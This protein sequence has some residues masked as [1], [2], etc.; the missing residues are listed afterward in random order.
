MNLQKYAAIDIGSNA[1]R[2]LISNVIEQGEQ[3]EFRKSSLIRLPIRLGQDA[4]T[5]GKISDENVDKLVTGMEAFHKLMKVHGVTK[6]KANATS[7]MRDAENGRQVIESIQQR[8]NI[9][10]NIIDGKREAEIIYHSFLLQSDHSA[11]TFLFIDVGGGSTELTLFDKDQTIA[12]KSFDIGTIRFLNGQVSEKQMAA[13]AA[14]VQKS[15]KPYKDI[16]I[17]GSGGNINK[18]HKIAGR[19]AGKPLSLGML[20]AIYIRLASLSYEQRM[21]EFGLNPDRADVIIPAGRIFIEIM[22]AIKAQT[23]FVP[24]IG[25]AD[26]QV[27]MLY[28][29]K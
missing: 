17:L 7:A 25:L 23:I 2:L 15:C 10:I 16:H 14:W 13:L 18:Y 1:V 11:H 9:D 3:V 6:Y 28:Y 20:K 12:S 27:R 29:N 26:G 5:L 8:A 19:K 24:R 4:F 21:T 22:E